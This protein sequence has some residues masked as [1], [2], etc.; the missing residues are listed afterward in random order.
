M[1]PPR[2]T[3]TTPRHHPDLTSPLRTSRS[4][5]KGKKPW[6]PRLSL[7]KR[8]S[9]QTGSEE[10]LSRDRRRDKP[11]ETTRQK[12]KWW[13]INLFEGIISDIRRRAPFYL[14]DWTDAWDY[15][16]IPATVYVFFAKY[17]SAKMQLLPSTQHTLVTIM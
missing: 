5:R 12:S 15:R 4:P 14:S 9:Y 13:K 11:T 17:V 2:A 6:E 7:S 1:A 8:R 16:V 3:Y 10:R